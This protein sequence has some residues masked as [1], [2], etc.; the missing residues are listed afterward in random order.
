MFLGTQKTTYYLFME[1]YIIIMSTLTILI[2]L[3]F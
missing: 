1:N 3:L 2:L